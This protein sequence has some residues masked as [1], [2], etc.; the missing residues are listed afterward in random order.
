MVVVRFQAYE[1]DSRATR[2][3]N[4]LPKSLTLSDFNTF[5]EICIAAYQ[6]KAFDVQKTKIEVKKL[7]AD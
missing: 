3:C 6:S 4:F 5:K 7:A 2:F 1:A